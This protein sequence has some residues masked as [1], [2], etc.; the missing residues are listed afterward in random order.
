VRPT[1]A[2]LVSGLIGLMMGASVPAAHAS[3]V[4][5]VTPIGASTSGPVNASATFVTG[6]G[7]LSVTLTDLQANP[8]D[9]AQTLSD[10]VFTLSTGQTTG[11]LTSSSGTTIFVS[12]AGTTTP[13]TTGSTG[14]G[15]NNNVSGGLQLDALGFIGPAGL[16]IGP[17]DAGG[18]YSNANGSIA[19][20]PA[21]NPFLDQT[22]TFLISVAGLTAADTV[23]SAA[24]SFGTTAGVE[25]AGVSPVPLPGALPLFASGL[26]GLVLLGRRRMKKIGILNT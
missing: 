5:F 24:F 21:H 20:N 19:G 13:G 11:T 23:T 8:T 14:W 16:I 26:V 25:I 22:A 17:P 6:A 2:A 12:G 15:L 7:T 3:T 10:L 4:T 18:L 1:I 9:V